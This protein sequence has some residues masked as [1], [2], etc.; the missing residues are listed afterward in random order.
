MLKL[1]PND[2]QTNPLVK[3]LSTRANGGGHRVVDDDVARHM[4]IG[5]ALTKKKQKK[6]RQFCIAM[7]ILYAYLTKR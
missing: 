2:C 1:T 4:K 3:R 5:D 6:R 7:P